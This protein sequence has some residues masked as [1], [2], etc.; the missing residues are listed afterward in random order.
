[1]SAVCA[2]D[3]G[4]ESYSKFQFAD[5]KVNAQFIE[6]L[7]EKGVKHKVDRNG[8]VTATK[9]GDCDFNATISNVREIYYPA[10]G[11]SMFTTDSLPL[12]AADLD[13]MEVAYRQVILA[14]RTIFAFNDKPTLD[15]AISLIDARYKDQIALELFELKFRPG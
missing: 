9:R 7:M 5:A 6:K 14:D 12:F 10:Y 11:F 1:M 4:P 13:E 8:Y 15:F 2:A 3:C